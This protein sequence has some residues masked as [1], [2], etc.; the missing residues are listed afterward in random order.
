MKELDYIPS[1]DTIIEEAEA[2]AD[3]YSTQQV[4]E[5]KRVR[6]RKVKETSTGVQ[7]LS[8][9]FKEHL[10][11]IGK[12]IT[13]SPQ[14]IAELNNKGKMPTMIKHCVV[15]VA[16]KLEGKM[17]PNNFIGAHNICFWSFNRYKL[18]K[19]NFGI[20]S[21]GQL[22]EKYHKSKADPGA[23]S[24]TRKYNTLYNKFFKKK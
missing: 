19:K 22:R 2:I 14:K 11:K 17:S 5:V 20:S 1:V 13:I 18:T 4:S 12:K 9:M 3:S 8:R 6:T 10:K 16:P 24:K 21:R 15:A 7:K 23:G